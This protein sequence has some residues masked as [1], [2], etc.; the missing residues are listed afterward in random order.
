MRHTEDEEAKSRREER[1]RGVIREC[2]REDPRPDDA[3]VRKVAI[4]MGESMR[5][6]RS[7][8]IEIANEEIRTWDAR[9]LG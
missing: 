5:V 7:R 1:L 8:S 2:L 9:N 3:E 4:E 6:L